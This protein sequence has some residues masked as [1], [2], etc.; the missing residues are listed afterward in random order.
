[1]HFSVNRSILLIGPHVGLNHQVRL[2]TCVSKPSLL[3]SLLYVLN[4]KLSNFI[5]LCCAHCRNLII[6][7]GE[8]EKC[9][10]TQNC[11]VM[12]FAMI[13]IPVL[14]PSKDEIKHF[15]FGHLS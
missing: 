3:I 10:Q 9:T 1:M 4:L 7:R 11:V 8:A 2:G 6:K 13:I 14:A 5:F 12:L 15:T